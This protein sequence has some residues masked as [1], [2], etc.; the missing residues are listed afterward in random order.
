MSTRRQPARPDATA[1]AP[2]EA[3]GLFTPLRLRGLVLRNRVVVSPMCQYSSVGGFANDWHFVH[4]GSR[5]VGGA[6][7]VISEATAVTPEGRISPQDLGVWSD[8]HVEGLARLTRFLVEHGAAAGIQLAHAGRKASTA[9]PWVGGRY[10]PPEEGGWLPVAPSPIPFRDGDPVPAALDAAGIRRVVAAFSDAARRALAAGFQV[11]EV[12]AAHGYLLHQFLSPLS[13]RRTDEYGGSF[14]GR[15]RLTFE[16]VEAVRAVWP[17]ELPLFV[18][19][20]ATDWVEGGWDLG[21][22]VM[23]ARLLRERGADLVDCSSGGA[24]PGVR[25]AAVPGYQTG[26]AERIR[27]EAGIATGAVGLITAPEQADESIRSGRADVVLLARQLLRDPY[28]P[29]H[30]AQRLGVA[31]AWPKQYQRAV[32]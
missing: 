13:N 11:V 19:I 28:W 23:L 31:L 16:V 5:A 22:S 26:F 10:V 24:V 30:A 14:E 25:I 18:R 8:A 29:L 12:H 20:S 15:V 3:P 1:T 7:L 21:Q 6:G 27:R 4:L 2:G 9:P 17:A 32:D